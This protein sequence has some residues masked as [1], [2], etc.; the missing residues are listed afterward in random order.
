LL[1]EGFSNKGFGRVTAFQ[2]YGGCTR[3]KDS[4]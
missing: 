1:V 3:A 4:Y 2:T